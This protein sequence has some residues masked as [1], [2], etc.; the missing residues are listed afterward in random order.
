[1]RAD[2]YQFWNP[3]FLWGKNEAIMEKLSKLMIDI[4]FG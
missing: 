2:G 3:G 4:I 1:M